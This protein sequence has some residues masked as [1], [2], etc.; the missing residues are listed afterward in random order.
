MKSLDSGDGSNAIW[1][2]HCATETDGDGGISIET[3]TWYEQRNGRDA[4]KLCGGIRGAAMSAAAEEPARRV[5]TMCH[6]GL[7]GQAPTP[8]AACGAQAG[9]YR[10]EG[11]YRVGYP[12]ETPAPFLRPT[13]EL[14]ETDLSCGPHRRVLQ[15][16]TADGCM[17]DVWL[18]YDVDAAT[19][20]PSNGSMTEL[21]NC[22]TP[23]RRRYF[24][25][26]IVR[27]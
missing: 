3:D 24:T 18:R 4:T 25:A 20:Q 22:A 23:N 2:Y 19:K 10:A 16:M 12:G 15:N 1:E 8:P 17:A 14:G 6:W 9:S 26:K 21:S 11:E 5:D 27:N 13:V 7:L